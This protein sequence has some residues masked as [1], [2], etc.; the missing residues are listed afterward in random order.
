M[1][2]NQKYK[3][4][5]PPIALLFN[6]RHYIYVKRTIVPFQHFSDQRLTSEEILAIVAHYILS[7]NIVTMLLSIVSFFRLM[8]Y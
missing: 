8:R 4:T 6:W 2:Y 5:E 3:L 7:H 1:E